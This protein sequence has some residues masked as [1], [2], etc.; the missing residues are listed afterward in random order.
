MSTT[1]ITNIDNAELLIHKNQNTLPLLNFKED[2]YFGILKTKISKTKLVKNPTFLLFTI[3]KTSSMTERASGGSTKMD[4]VIQTF[5]NIMFYLSKLDTEMYVQ[6]NTFNTEVDI[7]VDCVRISLDN[8]DN[9]AEKIKKII[10]NGST[11]IGKALI[12]ADKILR[13]Y[14]ELNKEHQ[15]AHIFMT[16]GDPTS[17]EVIYSVLADMVNEN[18]NN[19]FVGFGFNHNVE[20]LTKFG[21][22][23]KSEYQFVDNVENT[24]LVYGETIHKFIY[25]ALKD[26]EF[27]IENGTI[28]DWQKNEWTNSITEPIIISEIEKIYQIKTT[29]PDD[30]EVTICGKI[31]SVPITFEGDFK[32]DN[33]LKILDTVMTLP[34]LIDME[35]GELIT[36]DLTK[37]AFRQ[38]V[39]ELLF[40][41]RQYTNCK[42]TVGD[43][44]KK[45]LRNTFR[46]I[47]KYMR[48][49][50]LQEDGLLNMLC[51]DISIMYRTF[52]SCY[53]QL[54]A[55][56]RH[57]SQGR[58]R[59]YNTNSSKVTDDFEVDFDID[60]V[61]VRQNA[62][63][64]TLTSPPKL[65][66]TITTSCIDD[67]LLDTHSPLADEG[68]NNDPFNKYKELGFF[69]PPG[70]TDEP[71]F[72]SIFG[73]EVF[74][75]EDDIEYYIPQENNT[76]CYATPEILNTMRSISHPL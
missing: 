55:V 19:I 33:E 40:E 4:H 54:Y 27:H 37:Y 63:S 6:V 66:R 31:V 17:G 46:V 57:T 21:E 36:D 28:Y 74:I 43:V 64:R 12:L 61:F 50:N 59:T 5:V 14:E 11:D 71:V 65:S 41:A 34:D 51:D 8:V 68:I 24:S 44:Y 69:N 18:Y 75:K 72:K 62:L 10:P 9:I 47:R 29:N 70:S 16:D 56:S 2:E 49:N 52:G 23:K 26:V 48:I 7:L 13:D 20:L 45:K 38:K 60:N 73:D 22:K 30:V 67:E 58:Q 25:P 53:G 39:Q 15:I 42:R 32:I 35:T 1:M 76:T 3:D